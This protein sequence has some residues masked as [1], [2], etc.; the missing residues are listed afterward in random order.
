[1][2]F[3]LGAR[4]VRKIASALGWE[5]MLVVFEF[6]VLGDLETPLYCDLLM[7]G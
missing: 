6:G 5:E 7:S 2:D 4:G 1:M 3:F